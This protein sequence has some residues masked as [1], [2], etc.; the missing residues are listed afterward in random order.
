MKQMFASKGMKA[1]TLAFDKA[2]LVYRQTKPNRSR[3]PG[4]LALLPVPNG[5][6]QVISMDF[7]EGLPRSGAANCILVVVDKFLKYHY[8]IHLLHPFS[9]ATVAQA[10][11]NNIYMLHGM[12]SAIIS[13]RD[14]VFTSKLWQELFKLANVT[15]Q[16]SSVYHPQKDSQIERVSQCLKTFLHCFH[17]RKLLNLQG[18][19]PS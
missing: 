16:M 4:L 7:I 2:C 5:A 6:W 10:F 8:F 1:T 12:P 19:K 18:L 3:D 14:C 9:T 17:Y 11:L 15:L 13:D